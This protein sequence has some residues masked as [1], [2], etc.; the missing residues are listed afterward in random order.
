[1]TLL[2]LTSQ[3][4]LY[5]HSF[6]YH[7][8]H[9]FLVT[10]MWAIALV[11]VLMTSHS[12]QKIVVLLRVLLIVLTCQPW[13]CGY[14]GH[15]ALCIYL[16]SGTSTLVSFLLP[17]SCSWIE[18]EIL[19]C[20]GRHAT[21]CFTSWFT[22]FYK[23]KRLNFM[24]RNIPSLYPTPVQS[25]SYALFLHIARN[26]ILKPL[27]IILSLVFM[28]RFQHLPRLC[29]CLSGLL[30]HFTLCMW[31]VLLVSTSC[32]RESF[33]VVLMP[34][35]QCSLWHSFVYVPTIL[36]LIWHDLSRLRMYV[37]ERFFSANEGI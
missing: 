12:V 18:L 8:L 22:S 31:L 25:F 6:P 28:L 37:V 33:V 3:G 17:L 15:L 20:S 10:S 21:Q 23:P 9:L 11:S 30:Y 34:S 26:H 29:S 27:Y 36:V 13:R 19:F 32:N 35:R 5:T 16:E 14:G 2:Y 7:N 4:S 1:M 24:P